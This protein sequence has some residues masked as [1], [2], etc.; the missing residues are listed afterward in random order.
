MC[1]NDKDLFL[2]NSNICAAWFITQLSSMKFLKIILAFFIIL[3]LGIVSN[4]YW[5]V[6]NAKDRVYSKVNEVPKNKVG[7]LLGT[8]KYVAQGRV[9]LYYAHRIDAA[10]ALYK[11]GRI[12]YILISGDNGNANYDEPTTF[13]NDLIIRGIPE[14][15]IILD[16]AGF[17]TLDSVVRAK[18]IFGQHSYTIISQKFHN[19]RAIFLA[20]HLDVDAIAYNAKDVGKRYG[21][22]I[23]VR[24]FLARA[25]SSLDVVFNV[26]PKFLG[27]QIKIG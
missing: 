3:C 21:L 11:A 19:E 23:K 6:H 27:E 24:E 20:D 10:V 15:K 2:L 5:Y 25:K 8:S 9:N 12:E 17:R 14:D 1:I 16:F 13:K 4:N 7:L 18:E 22:K 26:K